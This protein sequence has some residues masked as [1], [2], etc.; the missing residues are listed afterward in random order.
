MMPG[1]ETCLFPT[2]ESLRQEKAVRFHHL[3]VSTRALTEDAAYILAA[4][5]PT[6]V[7]VHGT[8]TGQL[9]VGL[10]TLNVCC[11]ENELVRSILRLAR[12]SHESRG[13]NPMPPSAPTVG[14]LSPRETQVLRGGRQHCYHHLAPQEYHREAAP[15]KCVGPHYLRR[16]AWH[17]AGRG[18]L[19]G[20]P[21]KKSTSPLGAGKHPLPVSLGPA[22]LGRLTENIEH[23]KYNFISALADFQG[24]IWL[25]FFLSFPSYCVYMPAL[26]LCS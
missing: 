15:E 24:G 17:R 20:R 2:C 11:E 1:V 5:V 19:V 16:H 8:E 23:L 3:F 7:L 6:I 12:Q 10:P 26:R 22:L 25:E 14:L 4:R 9:P 21:Q 13:V 18:N